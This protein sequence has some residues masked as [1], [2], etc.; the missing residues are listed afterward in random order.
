MEAILAWQLAIAASLVASRIFSSKTLITV[1]LFWTAWT[2]VAV[3]ANGLI[4]LQLGTIWGAVWTLLLLF[5]RS[6]ASRANPDADDR[7]LTK[8]D[9]R[10]TAPEPISAVSSPLRA[11]HDM[12]EATVGGSEVTA[13]T[14]LKLSSSAFEKLNEGIRLKCERMAANREIL[15]ELYGLRVSVEA[16]LK[17]AE[18]ELETQRKLATDPCFAKAYTK[19]KEQVEGT[20]SLGGESTRPT[21]LGITAAP[22]LPADLP[23]FALEEREAELTRSREFLAAVKGRVMVERELRQALDKLTESGFLLFLMTQ[24]IVLSQH[25]AVLCPQE[26]CSPQPHEFQTISPNAP[27]SLTGF[28]KNLAQAASEKPKTAQVD[29]TG[30]GDF[31]VDPAPIA[32]KKWRKEIEL[33]ARELEVPH[34]VHFTRCENLEGILRTGLMSVAACGQQGLSPIRNDEDRFDRQLDG[35]SLSIAFPNYRMFYKYRQISKD[36]DWA[37]LLISPRVLW[38]KNCAFYRYN[39]ADAR[40][41]REPRMKMTSPEAFR[42]M[43]SERAERPEARLRR[44]DPSDPQAEVLVY[45]TIPPSY[46]EAVAFET[47]DARARHVEILAGLESFYAGRGKGLFGS[48]S[49]LSME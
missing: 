9:G 27:Q 10:H 7:M 13:A 29:L 21:L 34:L 19:V 45:E 5:G 32:P 33:F 41:S 14:S 38:E 1:A 47:Q 23:P 28:H 2:L 17:A 3:W 15:A 49:K 8:T 30:R 43:F 36:A 18:R 16:V 31:S 46:I 35:I 40:V 26:P 25:L 42:D 44:F 11:Q 37:V 39:A 4:I 20:I 12:S 6:V 24:E 22:N 48:R